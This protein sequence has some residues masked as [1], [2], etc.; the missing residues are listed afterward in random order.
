LGSG[1]EVKLVRFARRHVPPDDELELEELLDDEL[2]ELLPPLQLAAATPGPLT[3]RESML[4]VPEAVVAEMRM[5]WLPLG[6]ETVRETVL[7]LLQAPVTGKLWLP[8]LTLFTSTFT[9]RSAA[10]LA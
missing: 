7:Q 10:A 9:G 4:A 5:R 6:R 2:D 1:Y 3:C 8:W